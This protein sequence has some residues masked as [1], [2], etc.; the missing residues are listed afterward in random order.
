ME[1]ADEYH[2]NSRLAH[3]MNFPCT[4]LDRA[5]Y[6]RRSSINLHWPKNQILLSVT[7][8]L[9][10]HYLATAP[11]ISETEDDVESET[12]DVDMSETEDHVVSETDDI[13]MSETEEIK[14]ICTVLQNKRFKPEDC[15]EKAVKFH[16]D[17][18]NFPALTHIISKLST[19]ETEPLHIYDG[20]EICVQAIMSGQ[21]MNKE[22]SD[23]PFDM[24]GLTTTL[25][26]I[27]GI[28][29]VQHFTFVY[30]KCHN[31]RKKW[32]EKLPTWEGYND[33][34]EFDNHVLE[35]VCTSALDDIYNMYDPKTRQEKA[36]CWKIFND[37]GY[38]EIWEGAPAPF[39]WTNTSQPTPDMSRPEAKTV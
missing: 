24:S 32:E 38:H 36:F 4:P 30:G 25:R 39:P 34:E 28:A 26:R 6:H 33:A 13:V 18:F 21:L 7:I 9:L 3:D 2:S 29:R 10:R 20:F 8:Q 1:L 12:D 15:T 27:L 5:D 16:Y 11:E 23:Q 19:Y 14:W 31:L 22:V 35:E 17:N 37:V